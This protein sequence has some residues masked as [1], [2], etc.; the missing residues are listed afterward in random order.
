MDI[1]Q[2]AWRPLRYSDTRTSTIVQTHNRELMDLFLQQ[3]GFDQQSS[4]VVVYATDSP[5]TIVDDMSELHIFKFG[6]RKRDQIYQI[7][8]S[9]EI[10]V[11]LIQDVADDMVSTMS[12]GACALRGEIEIFSH[13]NDLISK[14]DYVYIQETNGLYREDSSE[15]YRYSGY[16]GYPCYES[17]AR[18]DDTDLDALYDELYQCA[19]NNN[20]IQPFTVEAYISLFTKE[21]LLGRKVESYEERTHIDRRG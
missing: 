11:S 5:K 10:M 21:Y 18:D 7:A 8:T 15:D 19:S 13:I 12:L 2:F 3:H 20:G 16:P 4:N 6:S 9:L 14:L 17:I 1:Y